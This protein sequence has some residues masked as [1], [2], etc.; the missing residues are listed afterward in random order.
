M[1]YPTPF[2][3]S[4]RPIPISLEQNT[5]HLPIK[6][7]IQCITVVFSNKAFGKAFGPKKLWGWMVWPMNGS[8]KTL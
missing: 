2:T 6:T 7:T 5:S 1:A 8:E 4:S 3:S